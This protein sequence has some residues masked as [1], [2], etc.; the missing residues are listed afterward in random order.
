[1]D[2]QPLDIVI[3]II[4]IIV[5]YVLLRLLIYKPVRKY[6]LERSAR[7]DNQMQEAGKAQ[8]DAQTAKRQYQERLNAAQQ[9][10][11]ETIRQSAQK[12]AQNAD[13]IIKGAKMQADAIL[14]DAHSRAEQDRLH[15]IKEMKEQ[16]TELSVDIAGKIL[17]REVALS[18]NR[19]L[20]EEFFDEVG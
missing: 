17:R 11:D 7:I 10:A 16:I 19:A 8:Q 14:R 18:D 2:I 6:M 13:E 12:A 4:N 1:M 5:L 3:H 20:V 15:T 9:D